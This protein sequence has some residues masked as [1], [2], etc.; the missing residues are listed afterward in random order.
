MYSLCVLGWGIVY[1]I[2][3]SSGLRG[4]GRGCRKQGSG[5]VVRIISWVTE[6]GE[7]PVG[8]SFCS[9]KPGERD[10]RDWESE[11]KKKKRKE[12][13][14]KSPSEREG[15][16]Y[17]MGRIKPQLADFTRPSP[18]TL[19]IQPSVPLNLL[20]PFL[21]PLSQRR[22]LCFQCQPVDRLLFVQ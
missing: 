16:C 5:C 13:Q 19:P 1:S 20:P 2:C 17:H 11:K 7:A 9:E 8:A 10:F 3:Q 21:C 12:G 15:A 18:P 22:S 6:N 4:K 14:L